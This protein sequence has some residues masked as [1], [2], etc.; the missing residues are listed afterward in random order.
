MQEYHDGILLFD[1]TD[2]M[3]WSKALRDTAGL[4]AFYETV[5]HNYMWDER[6]EG[7]IYYFEDQAFAKKFYKEI[8]K[9]QKKGIDIDIIYEQYNTIE[10]PQIPTETGIFIKADHPV[11]SSIKTAGITKPYAHNNKYIIVQ[12]DRIIQ[13][14]PKALREVKGVVTNEYQNYLEKEWIKELRAKYTWT[15]NE[16]VLQ[17][18]YR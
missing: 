15:V 7:T 10:E 18:L 12:T 6:V 8:S 17:T 5:K 11:F 13:P 4:N 2:K 16:D 3:V 9:A 14:E 1:L